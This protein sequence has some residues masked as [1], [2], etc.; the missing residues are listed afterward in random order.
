MVQGSTTLL[1]FSWLQHVQSGSLSPV[2]LWLPSGFW[3][4]A[5]A[6]SL[7]LHSSACP[8]LLSL[9]QDT[10]ICWA[11]GGCHSCSG[12]LTVSSL[13]CQQRW[14][15]PWPHMALLP[16]LEGALHL[17]LHFQ[18]CPIPSDSEHL[19]LSQQCPPP[20]AQ[21]LPVLP[22]L[23]S[24]MLCSQGPRWPHANDGGD[25]PKPH[26]FSFFP[27]GRCCDQF[28]E[29]CKIWE[30]GQSLGSPQEWGRY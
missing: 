7:K 3:R 6:G 30:S 13:P 9:S 26:G 18:P 5:K 19:S 1:Q 16:L 21:P 2:T 24:H 14:D 10:S 15:E 17:E 29:S 11:K 28:P 25:E 8:S 12:P 27:K 20:P 23:C 4:T 22:G